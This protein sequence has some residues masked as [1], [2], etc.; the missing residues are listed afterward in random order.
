MY[1]SFKGKNKYL[2][3]V[4]GGHNTRRP[5]ETLKKIMGLIDFHSN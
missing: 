5:D 1:D 4:K 3:I 2:E